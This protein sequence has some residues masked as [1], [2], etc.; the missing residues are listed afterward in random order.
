MV[1]V[2]EMDETYKRLL[3]QEIGKYVL[4][5]IG[6]SSFEKEIE[7]NAIC[8]LQKIQEIMLDDEISAGYK[9]LKIEDI[10]LDYN[11]QVSPI[12]DWENFLGS[13]QKIQKRDFSS[14]KLVFLWLYLLTSV[15][16]TTKPT[17]KILSASFTAAGGQNL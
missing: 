13:W 2:I 15:F 7:S 6:E 11:L 8:A 16:E 9:V 10:L 14:Q 4:E 12:N 5:A 3:C 1:E 17:D